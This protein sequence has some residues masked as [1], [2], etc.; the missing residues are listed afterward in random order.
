M[1]LRPKCQACRLHLLQRFTEPFIDDARPPPKLYDCNHPVH[2]EEVDNDASWL[3]TISPYGWLQ[4]S[5][6]VCYSKAPGDNFNL[7]NRQT[8]PHINA[9]P[10]TPCTGVVPKLGSKWPKHTGGEDSI[11]GQLKNVLLPHPIDTL[12]FR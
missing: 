12:R 8:C 10:R 5:C 11:R 6:E 4:D 2:S 7:G 1:A 3:L 9:R